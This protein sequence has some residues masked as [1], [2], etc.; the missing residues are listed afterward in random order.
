MRN[1][2]P[3]PKPTDYL[4]YIQMPL[5]LVVYVTLMHYRRTLLPPPLPI[6][7]FLEMGLTLQRRLRRIWRLLLR[8]ILSLKQKKRTWKLFL[9]R[10]HSYYLC[11]C[12]ILFISA[13]FPLC[14][15]SFKECRT[16]FI[17]LIIMSKIDEVNHT[18]LSYVI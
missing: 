8:R 1:V 6:R 16:R 4:I 5:N 10:M 9:E 2:S 14:L 7:W 11:L 18:I 15:F 13:W 12:M 17:H 3:I